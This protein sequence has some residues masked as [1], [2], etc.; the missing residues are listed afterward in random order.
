MTFQCRGTDKKSLAY[1][2]MWTISGQ[3]QGNYGMTEEQQQQVLFGF[4]SGKE[5]SDVQ[6]L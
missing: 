2:T 6:F 5:C 4:T 1:G 3:L